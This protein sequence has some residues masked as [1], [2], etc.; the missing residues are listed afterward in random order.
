MDLS[1]GDYFRATL[2]GNGIA[3]VANPPPRGL[4]GRFDLELTI[5]G[6]Y[7]LAWRGKFD[8]PDFRY[9]ERGTDVITGHSA[10]GGH[11]WRLNITRGQFLEEFVTFPS[12]CRF[13]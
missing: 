12:L 13:L 8:I 3:S 5:P 11:K 6:P 9:S 7:S 10:D 4:I 2:V 1:E